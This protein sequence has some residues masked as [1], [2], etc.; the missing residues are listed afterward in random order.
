M[1]KQ[2]GSAVLIIFW[3]DPCAN[4]F[5]KFRSRDVFFRTILAEFRK[6][7]P[8]QESVARIWESGQTLL[9]LTQRQVG[10]QPEYTQYR[11]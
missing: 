8:P 3:R 2:A 11:V 6:I 1:G 5:Y 9:V 7:W 4:C 10:S